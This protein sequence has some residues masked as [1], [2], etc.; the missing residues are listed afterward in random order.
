MKRLK[1][2]YF[3]IVLFFFRIFSFL[4]PKLERKLPL[5]LSL[6]LLIITNFKTDPTINVPKML[7]IKLQSMLERH[8]GMWDV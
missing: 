2:G 4:E 1:K 7:Y 3:F 5:T 6:Q 8:V